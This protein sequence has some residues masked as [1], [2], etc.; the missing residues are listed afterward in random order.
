MNTASFLKSFNE[1]A[2]STR[3][4]FTFVTPT[5][6]M[7]DWI[8]TGRAYVRAQLAADMLG[9]RFHSV[10][11]HC[12]NLLKWTRRGKSCKT[13]YRSMRPPRSKCSSGW[14][15]PRRPRSLLGASWL[16][17]FLFRTTALTVPPITDKTR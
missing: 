12:R 11:S 17:L 4:L 15:G 8:R 16:R 10:T 7:A 5:N 9:L 3:G 2:R 13:C 14:G 1:I 6:T